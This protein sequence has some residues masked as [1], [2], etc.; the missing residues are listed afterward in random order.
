MTRRTALACSIALFTAVAASAQ[1]TAR[2]E[3]VIQSHVSARARWRGS[4]AR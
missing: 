4:W 1:D 3:Q 2:M